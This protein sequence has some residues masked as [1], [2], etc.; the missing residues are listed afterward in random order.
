MSPQKPQMFPLI[1][2]QSAFS[3]SIIFPFANP[4]KIFSQHKMRRRA[5]HKIK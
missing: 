2:L 1:P 4:I 5:L 3:F